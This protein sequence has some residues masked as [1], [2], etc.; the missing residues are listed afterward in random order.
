MSKIAVIVPTIREE[1]YNTFLSKWTKLFIKH[2]IRLI[3][4]EDGDDPKLF[5]YIPVQDENMVY[6]MSLKDGFSL[7][8]EKN[9]K[10]LVFN[11]NDGVRNFGFAYVAKYCPEIEYIITLD[12]DTE[13]NGDTIQDHINALNQKVP[14][15]W[16]S[17]ANEYMRGF[18]YWVREEAEVVLSHGVWEGVPDWD[19]PT[20]LKL[21]NKTPEVY[22]NNGAIPKGIFYPMCGMNIAFKRKMLPFMYFAPMGH[23][24]GLDRFA[25]IWCGIN[26]KKEIDKRGWAVVT[27]QAIVFHKR[28][29]NVFTNLKKEAPGLELNETYWMGD[30]SKNPDY[31]KLYQ[32]SY[33]RWQKFVNMYIKKERR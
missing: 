11:K 25:D 7:S 1:S 6:Y 18:P 30:T 5:D 16:I 26:S 4:I 20:Q 24:V 17:T 29:S 31:F 23:K 22:F 15:S 10:D 9:I 8:V 32:S 28:A 14:V 19:A 2:D 27:G 33:K 13:P 3:K 12:D 21:G